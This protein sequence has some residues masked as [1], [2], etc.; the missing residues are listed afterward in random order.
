[1][2]VVFVQGG[3]ERAGGE[4]VLLALLRRL[5]E[6]GVEPEVL[7]AAD[8]P[9]LDEV[10]EAGIAVTRLK[11][12]ARLREVRRLPALVSEIAESAAG[13]GA[14]LIHANGEKMS[15]LSAWAGRR[16]GIPVIAWLHDEPM[17]SRGPAAAQLA[18]RLSPKTHWAACSPWMAAAFTKRLRHETRA[19][20]N[21]LDLESVPA[22][23][24]DPRVEYGW[25][26][27]SVVVGYFG[28]LER[29]KGP[30][31]FIEAA[32]RVARDRPGVR[33]LMV[34]G[35]LFGR[36]EVFAASLP[37]MVRRA[38]LTD[39]LAMTGHRADAIGLMGG[40]DVVAHTSRSPEPFG[41]V[42]IEAMAMGTPVVATR[43]GGPEG[44]IDDQRNGLLVRPDDASD[45]A[46]AI[47]SLVDEPDRR[48][49][50]GAAGQSLVRS[51]YSARAMAQSFADLYAEVT[52]RSPRR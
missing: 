20:S 25:P 33:F 9:F 17:R 42:V 31:V 16:T 6:V 5:P 41:M 11:S 30:D 8:G 46:A 27:D 15:L 14:D 36:D 22:E 49:L 1:M 13:A 2:K 3:A 10:V 12:R 18:L 21:G 26:A 29:W 40:C 4:R 32:E 48:A 52:G 45:L 43:T 50:L 38:G 39:R 44:I 7:F 19:V 37:D 47:A 35:A 34:G 28:R 23:A 24:V 51:R